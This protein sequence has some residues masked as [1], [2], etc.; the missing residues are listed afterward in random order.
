MNLIFDL[1]FLSTAEIPM[2][3]DGSMSSAEKAQRAMVDRRIA[4]L[5][6]N[7]ISSFKVNDWFCDMCDMCVLFFQYPVICSNLSTGYAQAGDDTEA[8]HR[9]GHHRRGE[10]IASE[11]YSRI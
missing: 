11:M 2:A 4:E 8:I 6:P 10:S 5:G 1:I 7:H 9:T 3:A